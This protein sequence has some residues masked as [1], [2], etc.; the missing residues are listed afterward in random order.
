[1]QAALVPS[2]HSS[3]ED[4]THALEF[5]IALSVCP[6]AFTVAHSNT[7]AE[8]Q[9]RLFIDLLPPPDVSSA[10]EKHGKQMSIPF[11]YDVLA[12]AE[13]GGWL[14]GE[15][16]ILTQPPGL[17]LDLLPFQTR[18]VRWLLGREGVRVDGSS[19]VVASWRDKGK[20]R[21]QEEGSQEGASI[22]EIKMEDDSDDSNEER[23]TNGRAAGLLNLAS[24]ATSATG[25]DARVVIVPAE[26]DG[27][28]WA[29]ESH[30]LPLPPPAF[31]LA[32]LQP[33]DGAQDD[34]SMSAEDEQKKIWFNRLDGMLYRT[35]EDVREARDSWD[36]NCQMGGMLCEEM[37]A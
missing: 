29:F 30:S 10:F 12:P 31:P 22:E 26:V 20:G 15:E 6:L 23:F 11:F 24:A 34:E 8:A 37:G 33:Q 3:P 9:R 14:P 28:S 19:V 18:T 2:I 27:A 35:E 16:E 4:A 13:S 21:A 7:M 32:E 1:M 36:V 5:T 25:E 17:K